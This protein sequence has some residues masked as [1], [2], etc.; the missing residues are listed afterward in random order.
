M[1]SCPSSALVVSHCGCWRV[2]ASIHTMAE[3]SDLGSDVVQHKEEQA[4]QHEHEHEHHAG[5]CEHHHRES[6]LP[7]SSPSTF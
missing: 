5:H 6:Q 1:H 4:E 3:A 2:E 7:T